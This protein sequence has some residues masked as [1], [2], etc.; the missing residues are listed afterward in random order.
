MKHEAPSRKIEWSKLNDD[1]FVFGGMQGLKYFSVHANAQNGELRVTRCC[2]TKALEG[3]LEPTVPAITK[4][5][6]RF[7]KMPRHRPCR[8]KLS[9]RQTRP[10]WK[11]SRRWRSR[12]RKRRAC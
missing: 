10:P 4:A 3:I 5:F 1:G 11:N 6:T 12:R 7:R 2:S 8:R 9:I